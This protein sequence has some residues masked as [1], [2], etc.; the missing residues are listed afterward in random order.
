MD[1]RFWEKI[2]N[3]IFEGLVV[4]SPQGTVVAVNQAMTE[5]TGYRREE[6]I[7][8]PCAL[9]KTDQCVAG[10]VL[11][12]SK[13]C[14]LFRSGRIHR[15]RCSL[16]RKDGGLVHVV[17]NAVLMPGE[18]GQ[19][20][21]VET[22]A[23]VS[24]LVA[25][26]RVVSRLR[27]EL[28]R[29][30]GFQGMIGR[31][32]AMR[33]LFALIESA[34]SSEAPVMILGESGTGKEL[35]AGAIHRLSP[36]SQGPF[37]KVNSAALHESLL[38]SELFGHVKGAFTG[39]DRSRIGRFEAAHGGDL[40]LDEIGDL[41]MPT[42]AKLL[43]VLQEKVVERVGDHTPIPVDVRLISAT[44]KDLK[45]LLVAGQ[46][47]EDLFYRVNVIPIQV[48]ALRE[49]QGD[50][51]L[52]V[53]GFLKRIRLK[54]KKPIQSISKEALEML[55]GYHWPGNV[56]ELINVLEFAFVLCGGDKILPAHLPNLKKPHPAAR[57]RTVLGGDA[58]GVD[59]A[60]VL[61]QTLAAANGNKA[62]AARLLGISRVTLWKR[63][64][65]YGLQ[66]LSQEDV[67]EGTEGALRPLRGL[68]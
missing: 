62:E 2:V 63:L 41:P 26:E 37:I 19:P 53:E 9:V 31:S 3:A 57:P 49:R 27:R 67:E 6:L 34:A 12:T 8:Q 22:F 45:Q 58:G 60:A 15:Q 36:R 46:F 23:D 13:V 38:E 35:V 29:E 17:K 11:A 4:I 14:E 61:R 43:R 30:D 21:A 40:F 65:K 47:R 48:P 10:A 16:V 64:K 51:P 5:M 56:R 33:R 1:E 66:G 44:N 39:A 24:E 68:R 18:D 32:P 28:S 7:G 52:L 20:V 59:E 55:M 54:T 50:I 25:Q 42:Q